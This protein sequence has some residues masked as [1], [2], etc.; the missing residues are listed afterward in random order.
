MLRAEA[1]EQP[2]E[3]PGPRLER[4]DPPCG[5]RDGPRATRASSSGASVKTPIRDAVGLK[6][7]ERRGRRRARAEVDG[8]VILGE[9]LEHRPPVR[10]LLVEP[11]RIDLGPPRD[12]REPG[13]IERPRVAED[14]VELDRDRRHRGRR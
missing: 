11:V 7:P 8:R 4:L 13:V 3:R 5:A 10:Q 12:V 6:P 14:A 2:L 9:S 1:L